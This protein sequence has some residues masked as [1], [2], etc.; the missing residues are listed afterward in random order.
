MEALLQTINGILTAVVNYFRTFD[1]SKV[2]GFV[3]MIL[4]NFNST[5]IKATFEGLKIF[6][7]DIAS[8][9]RG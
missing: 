3:E 9:I 1:A 4:K 7:Q 5:T 8:M 2:G 6:L